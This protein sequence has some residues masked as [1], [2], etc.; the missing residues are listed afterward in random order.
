MHRCVDS[1]LRSNA[2][3]LLG[4]SRSLLI[5]TCGILRP[6]P[7]ELLLL[8][9]G[10]LLLSEL[11]EE[12]AAF[13]IELLRRKL[14]SLQLLHILLAHILAL[15]HVLTHLIDPGSSD[16]LLLQSDAIP[17]SGLGEPCLDLI[18][19][20]VRR[21]TEMQGVDFALDLREELAE[22]LR[23]CRLRSLRWL[24]LGLGLSSSLGRLGLL[25][26]HSLLLATLL[27]GAHSFHEIL[28]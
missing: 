8:L 9:E 12:V 21:Q 16:F 27:E 14:P 24:G 2:G 6:G 15:V 5:L 28:R 7:I 11:V 1:I 13:A 26:L 10:L 22:A 3:R 23:V 18:S 25:V 19:I 4:V 20:D 17:E